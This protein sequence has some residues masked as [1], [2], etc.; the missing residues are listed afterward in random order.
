MD[1][2][3]HQ[4]D[5]ARP[6]GYHERLR[7]PRWWYLAA[8]GV[9]VLLGLE[10]A[11]AISGWVA[12]APFALLLPGALLTVWR[13]SSGSVSVDGA[14]LRAGERSVAVTEIEQAID[15]SPTELRRLVGRHSD[16]LAFTYIRSWVGPGVQLVLRPPADPPQL[17]RQA[18]GEPADA[19]QAP[20]EP[21]DPPQDDPL[22]AERLP[23]PYWV[24]STRHP[25]QLLAALQAAQAAGSRSR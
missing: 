25:D 12:W 8:V 14:T 20:G 3:T 22:P 7:T 16:P 21:A 6:A 23:E 2:A 4:P 11:V 13:L 24:V 15:L 19:R 17:G 18:P 10:F 1:P 5:Q 9:A